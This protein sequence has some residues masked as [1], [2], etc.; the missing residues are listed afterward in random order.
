MSAEKAYKVRAIHCSHKASPE[1][2][3]ERLKAITAPLTRSWEK[4]EKAVKSVSR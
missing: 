4:I 1:E 3:Y 2:I